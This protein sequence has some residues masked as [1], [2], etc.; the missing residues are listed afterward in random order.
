M[1]TDSTNLSDAG[2]QRRRAT[3]SSR[4]TATSTCPTRPATYRGKVKN[5]QEAHEAIR[6][7]G[8]GH[9][10]ARRRR[11]ASCAARDER[12]LYELIWMRTIACQMADARD[13]ARHGAARRDV[14]DGRSTLTF[15]ATG[16]T[17]E[18]PGYL[19]AYVEGADDPDAELEDREAILPAARRGRHRRVPGAARVGPHDAAAGALHRGEPRQG[20]R[21]A[22]H[23]SPVDVR[24]RH[25]HAAPPRLRV[26]EGERARPDLDRVREAAAARAVLRAPHRLRVH[27]ARWR[28]R[29]TS[30]RVVRARPRSGCTRSTSATASPG[31]RELV[32]RGSPRA[33]STSPR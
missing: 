33:R 29:S 5:A 15:Q 16:R 12:R 7:A 13:P 14:D 8:D 1:R 24:G 27:R 22:R 18:F 3:R 19:R 26:E 2:A 17:I 25:R 32:H 9:P 30:S 6:P 23:R 4:S 31:L 10:H 11:A 20:A 21:G 28:R